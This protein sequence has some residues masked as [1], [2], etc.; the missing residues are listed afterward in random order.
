LVRLGSGTLPLRCRRPK[1]SCVARFAMRRGAHVVG[2]ANFAA[3]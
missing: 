3:F 1:I 2:E